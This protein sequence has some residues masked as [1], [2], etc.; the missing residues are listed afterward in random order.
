MDWGDWFVWLFV[1]GNYGLRAGEI[2]LDYLGRPSGQ[3]Q[4]PYRREAEDLTQEK[5]M[6]TEARCH[7]ASSERRR[8]GSAVNERERCSRRWRKVDSGRET[9][10]STFASKRE[11]SPANTL[12]LAQYLQASGLQNCKR[13]HLCC[14]KPQNLKYIVLT[15]TEN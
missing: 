14:L 4:C 12:T 7:S 6:R 3:S 11:S 1:F 9:G 5:A 8:K 13:I 15:V 10:H 2:I